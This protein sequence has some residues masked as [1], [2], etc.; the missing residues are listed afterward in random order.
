MEA[1]LLESFYYLTELRVC[2]LARNRGRNNGEHFVFRVVLALLY[3][4]NNVEHIRLVRYRTEWALVDAC[5]A[6]YALVVVYRRRLV[7][8][9]ADSLYLARH[10]AGAL[11]VYN[12]GV[13]ADSGARAALLAFRLV[14]MRNVLAV[15]RECAEAA[16]ILTAV[17]EA[18]AAGVGDFVSAH[19][20]LVAGDVDNLYNV[21][22][23]ADSYLDSLAEYRSFFVDTAAHGRRVAGDDG[24]R[25]LEKIFKQRVV[26]CKPRDL[27]QDFIF[28]I[29]YLSVEFSH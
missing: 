13:G 9:H 17:G 19:G 16:D 5:A 15:K 10:L 6:G 28:K 2:K 25:Y 8:V 12:R 1:E 29:L 27:A 22:V 11:A 20:T 4:I 14:D 26:P 23:A 18:S 21:R 24:F 3:N 7:L